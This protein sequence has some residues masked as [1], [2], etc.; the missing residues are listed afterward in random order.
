MYYIYIILYN[1]YIYSIYIWISLDLIEAMTTAAACVLECKSWAKDLKGSNT[2]LAR[3]MVVC[4]V[5]LRVYSCM[6]ACVSMP[7][8]YFFYIHIYIIFYIWCTEAGA[9]DESGSR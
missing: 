1:I 4:R 6:L 3:V 8:V 9:S 5:M 7:R 2:C